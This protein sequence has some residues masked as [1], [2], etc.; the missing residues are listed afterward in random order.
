MP[1]PDTFVFVPDPFQGRLHAGERRPVKMQVGKEHP[2][3]RHL[4][5]M[6]LMR[7]VHDS[8]MCLLIFKEFFNDDHSSMTSWCGMT[9]GPAAGVK[10]KPI[11]LHDSL[12]TNAKPLPSGLGAGRVPNAQKSCVT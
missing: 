2:G 6:F 7:E 1:W 3:S 10:P 8:G 5:R 12:H 11:K 4:F 9:E